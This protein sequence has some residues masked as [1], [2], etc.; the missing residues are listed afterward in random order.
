[1]EGAYLTQ[2]FDDPA[3]QQPTT[4]VSA[5]QAIA[6]AA[7]SGQRIY[8][9]NKA[10]AG[11]ISALQIDPETTVSE[12]SSAVQ[13]GLEVFKFIQRQCRLVIGVVSVT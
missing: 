3:T 12:I 9:I 4:S 13:A 2:F 6:T 11:V 5:V 8:R 10:N 1:M 7:Q